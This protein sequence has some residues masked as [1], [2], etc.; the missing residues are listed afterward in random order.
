MYSSIAANRAAVSTSR[1][2]KMSPLN[3]SSN[4]TGTQ[5]E[6]QDRPKK[7]W[8]FAKGRRTTHALIYPDGSEIHSQVGAA[9]WCPGAGRKKTRYL[10]DNIRST[11]YSAKLVGLQLAL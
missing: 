8:N 6:L 9:A 7:K 3:L 2:I 10:G 4:Y 11:I 5:N 1:K